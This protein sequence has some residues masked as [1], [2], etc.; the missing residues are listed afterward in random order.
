MFGVIDKV[1]GSHVFTCSPVLALLINPPVSVLYCISSPCRQS[2]CPTMISL[3]G[4]PKPDIKTKPASDA[5]KHM[6]T[7]LS[8]TTAKIIYR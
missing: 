5:S 8:P 7:A 6:D 3:L 4:M 2:L 1:V